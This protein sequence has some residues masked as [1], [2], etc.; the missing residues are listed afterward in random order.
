MY[1]N[2]VWNGLAIVESNGS[3]VVIQ[4]ENL[5]TKFYMRNIFKA[6][7]IGILRRNRSGRWQYRWSIP[8]HTCCRGQKP[9]KT[10]AWDYVVRCQSASKFFLLFVTAFTVRGQVTCWCSESLINKAYRESFLPSKNQKIQIV[11]GRILIRPLRYI[12]HLYRHRAP[13]AGTH[14]L[15]TASR[16]C[17]AQYYRQLANPDSARAT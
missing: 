15:Y 7:S 6:V 13:F 16:S 4:F 14:R 10:W 1:T 12:R 5:Y 17:E 11:N 3:R 2:K 9:C 8:L